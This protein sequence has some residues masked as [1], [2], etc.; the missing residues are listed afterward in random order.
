MDV[1]I[2]NSEN[3]VVEDTS[4]MNEMGTFPRCLSLAM[5]YVPW[6]R[7]RKLYEPDVGFNRG[8]LFEELDLPFIGEGVP[9]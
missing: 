3:I 7:F 2:E 6:Q 8:T 4:N 1:T 5:A 9:K